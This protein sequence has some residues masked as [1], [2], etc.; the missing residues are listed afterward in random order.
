[1]TL[2]DEHTNEK[3][4]PKHHTG[5]TVKLFKGEPRNATQLRKG[6][7]AAKGPPLWRIERCRIWP[8]RSGDWKRR[9]IQAGG[10]RGK[11]G[12]TEVGGWRSARVPK[13]TGV[14]FE[15]CVEGE[16]TFVSLALGWFLVGNGDKGGGLGVEGSFVQ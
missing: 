6:E 8:G 13:H 7:S 1:M 16:E 9:V 15:R 14:W 4:A 2:G 12:G 3:N 11:V 10:E 5:D